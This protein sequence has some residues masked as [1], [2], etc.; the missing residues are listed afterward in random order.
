LKKESEPHYGVEY[1]SDTQLIGDAVCQKLLP[2]LQ[3]YRSLSQGEK[4][5]GILLTGGKASL[6][7]IDSVLARQCRL[8]CHSLSPD[9]L[10]NCQSKSSVPLSASYV[11][12][13]GIAL[14]G[15]NWIQEVDHA[16]C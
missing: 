2:Q 13:L 10:I 4:I 12:A 9:R 11:T 15:A 16:R 14:S 1:K 8:P 3:R 5:E 7:G 6:E